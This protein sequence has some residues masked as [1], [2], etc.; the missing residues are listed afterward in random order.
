MRSQ[1]RTR[2]MQRNDGEETW[3]YA[4]A[5]TSTRCVVI[6][7][8]VP[9]C[10]FTHGLHANSAKCEDLLS[11]MYTGNARAERKKTATSLPP[12][13][14]IIHGTCHLVDVLWM[15][16]N[17]KSCCTMPR[18]LEIALGLVRVVAFCENIIT[19]LSYD[20]PLLTCLSA[21]LAA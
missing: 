2:R 17:G 6:I 9:Y 19:I 4:K 18:A 5:W 7:S 15:I 12:P 8:F 14:G 3:K 21:Y 10:L 1:W 20:P 13:S 16:H 11:S